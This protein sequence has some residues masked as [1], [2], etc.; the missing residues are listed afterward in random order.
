MRTS[1]RIIRK[2][3]QHCKRFKITQIEP[4]HI[5][6]IKMVKSIGP[7]RKEKKS[8]GDLSYVR[9]GDIVHSWGQPKYC[10]TLFFHCNTFADE[11]LSADQI[12]LREFNQMPL[13]IYEVDL[14]HLIVSWRHWF[15][16]TK[17]NILIYWNQYH[18][19]LRPS[20]KLNFLGYC[21]TSFGRFN[22]VHHSLTIKL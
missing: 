10:I 8:L 13:A 18:F 19:H 20:V 16:F 7:N 15:W 12:I 21:N 14:T 1:L 22:W 3:H 17:I 4:K 6:P 2:K 11:R 5:L 9:K